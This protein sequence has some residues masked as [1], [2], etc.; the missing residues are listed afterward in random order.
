MD[1]RQNTLFICQ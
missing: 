1:S